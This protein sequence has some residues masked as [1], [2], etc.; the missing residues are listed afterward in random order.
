MARDVEELQ[1]VCP[2]T[3]M[4][5]VVLGDGRKLTAAY[6]GVFDLILTSP[7]YPNNIDYNEIYKLELWLLGFV[8]SEAAFLGLRRSTYR[9]HPT[10]RPLDD[11]S[12]GNVEFKNLLTR[13]PLKE[14]VGTVIRRARALDRTCSRGRSKVLMGYLYDTWCSIKAHRRALKPGGRAIYVV[15]NSLHGANDRPYLIPTDL[16]VACLGEATGFCVDNLMVARPL[17]RRLAG[18]HFLRDSLVVLRNL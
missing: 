12:D 1:N 18:N 6:E 9:S 16:I 2:D 4:A 5:K 3:S 11:E 15:G 17:Q 10:C 8:T 7:P 13:G 14:L